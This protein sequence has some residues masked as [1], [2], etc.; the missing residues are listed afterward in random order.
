MQS[1]FDL[2]AVLTLLSL[3]AS[4]ALAKGPASF[5]MFTQLGDKTIEGQP[6]QWSDS[7]MYLLGRDGQLH[8]FHPRAAQNSKKTSP[9]FRGYPSSE[10]QARLKEEFGRKFEITTTEHFAVVHPRGEQW[11]A[12]ADRLEYL[13]RSF[14]HRMKARGFRLREPKVMLVA[15]VFLNQ[16]EYYRHAANNGKP[17]SPG[18]LGHY[19]PKSNRIFLFDAPSSSGE[20]WS[21]TA[22]TIIH[23]ATHQTA[24]NVGVHR[25]FAEQPRWLVEGLA[26]VFEARGM[27]DARSKSTLAKRVNYSRLAGF[28]HYQSSRPTGMIKSLVSSD[29]LFRTNVGFAYAESWALSFFLCETQPEK[30]SRYLAKVA[31]RRPFEEYPAT[32][33]MVDFMKVFGSDFES[34][35]SELGKFVEEL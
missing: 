6:L 34:L 11:G 5:M 15:V 2:W 14:T 35:E 17:L 3:Q 20:D 27:W 10:M 13:Y 22:R 28:R 4:V 31:S 29:Q 12:W 8:T 25:R 24:Y 21:V 9:V 18:T 23:E 16:S 19:D 30:Y 1:R 26:M 32:Q 33:R 7:H